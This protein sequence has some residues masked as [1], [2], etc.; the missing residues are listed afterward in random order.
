MPGGRPPIPPGTLPML[1]ARLRFAD[2]C[3][4]ETP[5]ACRALL[6]VERKWRLERLC[7]V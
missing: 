3:G 5:R 2:S 7:V 1:D 4:D 6:H